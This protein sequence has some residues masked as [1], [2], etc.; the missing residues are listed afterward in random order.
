MT[1]P[2]IEQTKMEK[3]NN[4]ITACVNLLSVMYP[5]AQ[6]RIPKLLKENLKINT[7]SFLNTHQ[8]TP[9]KHYL[10]C[11]LKLPFGVVL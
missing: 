6:K 2:N 5:F 10:L 8:K 1:G 3:N 7:Y 4:K 11:W 9:P